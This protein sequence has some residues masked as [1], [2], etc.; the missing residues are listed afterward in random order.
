MILETKRLSLREMT[1][2]DFASLCKILQD[3]KVMYAYEGAFSNEEV[4]QW[5]DRQIA[6]YESYGHRFGLYAVICKETGD[7][8]GQCG[9]TMQPWKDREVL[10]VGYLFRRDCWHKGY[11]TEAAKTCKEYAFTTLH[12]HEV[13]SIIRDTN[14]P[15]QRVALRNGMKS[16][17]TWTKHYRGIDMPHLL[18]CVK[19]SNRKEV[20]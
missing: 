14:L 12:A 13:Y 1:Q 11:A 5:L 10:E 20:L 15:S 16:V 2:N 6:R 8:I 3:E 9:L 19:Q 17:D 7:M 18:F 4:Q